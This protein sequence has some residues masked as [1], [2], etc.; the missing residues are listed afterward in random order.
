MNFITRTLSANDVEQLEG[1]QKL[2]VQ[3]Y[4]PRQPTPAPLYLSPYFA[5]GQN[6]LC[7][8][9]PAGAL[10][11]FAPYFPQNDLA[12]VEV[13]ARPGLE[14]AAEVKEALW[15]WILGRARQDGLKKLC[16]QYF[17]NEVEAIE[18]AGR[19][20]GVY[21]YSIFAMRRDLQQA[22]PALAMAEGFGL[23]RWRMESEA[24]Q[25]QY[26]EGRNECFPE[27]PTSL[28]E[29]QFFARSTWWEQGVNMAAFDGERLAASVLVFWEPGSSSGS[30]EYVFT[31]AEY[32]GRGLARTL[33]AEAMQYL[34]DHGLQY[35][36]LEVRA[37]NRAALGAYLGLG[38]EVT[39]ESQ[40]YVVE[41][42]KG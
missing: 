27:A 32:R 38:Y 31:R 14:N 41:V 23:R 20:G 36:V 9:D 24:E 7:A 17:P 8:F 6:V 25:H 39:A 30:T 37:E 21:S 29:W 26:L 10:L 15:Q 42:E 4:P 13:E 22:I 28:E 18:F 19:Q 11:A 40:V 16:F 1:L 12:W 35:A 5:E 3:A 34:K 2:Y 33:L